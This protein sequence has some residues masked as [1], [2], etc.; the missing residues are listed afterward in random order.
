MNENQPVYRKNKSN[1]E[2][3]S[4]VLKMEKDLNIFGDI[5]I[6]LKNNGFYRKKLMFRFAFNTAFIPESK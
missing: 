3:P 1:G 6:K 4:I 2:D 5:L